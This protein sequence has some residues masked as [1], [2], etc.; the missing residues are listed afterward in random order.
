MSYRLGDIVRMKKPHP[1]GSSTWEILR[2][3]ADF[4]IK[5]TGC[6]RVVMLTRAQFMKDV[7]GIADSGAGGDVHAESGNRGPA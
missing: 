4:R 6:G 7:R 1:C 3:G 2:V 5:C